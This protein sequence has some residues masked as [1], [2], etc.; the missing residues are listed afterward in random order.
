MLSYELSYGRAD[1]VV[2]LHHMPPCRVGEQVL[3][4]ELTQSLY[5]PGHGGAVGRGGDEAWRAAGSIIV[6]GDNYSSRPECR[7]IG[8]EGGDSQWIVRQIDHVSLCQPGVIHQRGYI[9]YPVPGNIQPCQLGEVGEWG[10]V[11]WVRT[12]LPFRF[13]KTT[14]GTAG[15]TSGVGPYLDGTEYTNYTAT[16]AIHATFILGKE[17][18]GCTTLQGNNYMSPG[19]ITK[20]PGPSDTSNP[21][22]RF[23]TVGWY[24]PFV[25]K[26]LNPMFAMQIWS[27]P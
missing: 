5:V 20:K 12:T 8:I 14:V 2:G 23:S 24:L 27:R 4:S 6:I 21:L 3:V 18:F 19:I 15:H 11:R 1:R 17:A 26:G 25:S 16:G 10:G 9:A 7:N 13:P 22:N